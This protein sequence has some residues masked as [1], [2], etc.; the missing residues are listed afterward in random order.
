MG[1]LKKQ[2]MGNP[3]CDFCATLK[4]ERTL[5]HNECLKRNYKAHVKTNKAY[6]GVIINNYICDQ[7]KRV[8]EKKTKTF[9]NLRFCP[10]CGFDFVEGKQYDG[11]FYIGIN[12]N[13]LLQ[14]MEEGHRDLD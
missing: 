2:M 11:R 13:H 12:F 9:S 1:N 3:F 5:L 6:S 8:Y 4:F 7:R 10:I 14:K